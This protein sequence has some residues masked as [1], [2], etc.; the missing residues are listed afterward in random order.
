M[1]PS[2]SLAI[3]MV[4]AWFEGPAGLSIY[5]VPRAGMGN[6]VFF[7][8]LRLR[9]FSGGTFSISEPASARSD[10]LLRRIRC[11]LRCK[12]LTPSVRLCN[13]IRMGVPNPTLLHFDASAATPLPSFCYA[14][15]LQK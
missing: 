3:A 9:G 2:F 7:G 11:K 8:W 5:L 12:P 6:M 13:A 4:P 1:F 10:F 14:I 15:A